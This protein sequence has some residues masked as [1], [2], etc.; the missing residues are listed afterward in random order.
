MS[1]E[2]AMLLEG[3]QY[4]RVDEPMDFGSQFSIALWVKPDPSALGIQNLVGNAPGGWDTDGF[5]LYYN[6][7]SD[8]STADGAVIL[9]TGDGVD[10]GLAGD[11]VRTPVGTVGDEI[12]TQIAT[13]VDIDAGEALL[14]V[15]GLITSTTGGLNIDMKTDSPFEIGRMI[16][17]WDLHGLIDD[18]QIY[19]GV[20][21]EEEVEW[22]FDNPGQFIG[23]VG[24][25]GDYNGNDQLDAGDLDMQAV[26]IAGGQNPKEY[27]LNNDDLVNF[28]DREVW[29]ND[30]KNT[31]IGDANLNGEFNS[32][33]M[34]QVFAR[35]L[36]ETGNPAGWEDGDF[37]GDT[38]FGSGD[39]VAAFV[40]GGYEKGL[41]PGGPP[42]PALSAV[43]EPGSVV[44]AL[45]GLT[46]VTVTNRRT[47]ARTARATRGSRGG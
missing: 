15:D 25:E 18:V 14:Y 41:R 3:G 34:V 7:W 44:L 33:D 20:L 5:K 11:A 10:V 4:V 2:L 16:G 8:P 36:Y 35:G 39:M 22:L 43:P 28:A 30:L 12:W 23:D 27:D 38:V 26:A 6:T 42:N 21:T 29:V 17:S 13:T 31:W 1:G 46:L 37:N 9:E 47:A 19:E 32:G 45:L 24:I 40:G